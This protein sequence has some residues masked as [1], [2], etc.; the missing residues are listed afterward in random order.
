MAV[1]AEPFDFRLHFGSVILARRDEHAPPPEPRKHQTFRLRAETRF[2]K[3]LWI[4][5]AGDFRGPFGTEGFFW[6]CTR[7]DVSNFRSRSRH[8]GRVSPSGDYELIKNGGFDFWLFFGS[9]IPT[10]RDR[11]CSLAKASHRSSFPAPS[12]D[13]IFQNSP[14]PVPSCD[15][16]LERCLQ[17]KKNGVDFRPRR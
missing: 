9:I 11:H 17:E 10:R 12:G 2:F 14:G 15:P 5:G 8:R 4:N 16:I 1:Q 7:H 6:G 3:I 13:K